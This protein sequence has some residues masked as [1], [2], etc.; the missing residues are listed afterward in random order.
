MALNPSNSSNLEQLALKG[1]NPTLFYL[2]HD[3]VGFHVSLRVTTVS[4]WSSFAA[5]SNRVIRSWL[6]RPG[7]GRSI[8]GGSRSDIYAVHARSVGFIPRN[9]V[10]IEFVQV[11]SRSLNTRRRSTT[12]SEDPAW[13]SPT[14]STPT[15]KI[16]WLRGTVV[17]RRP[18]TGELS[19]SC[20]R[21][22]AD[23]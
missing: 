2:C 13:C 20:A 21:P 12:T 16:G 18:L 1:L 15:A 7:R 22:A 8:H 3:N 23:G 5:V 10:P 6:G 9:I 19:L 11:A 4:S 14:S 17:E